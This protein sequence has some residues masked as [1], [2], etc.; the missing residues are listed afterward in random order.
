MGP[1]LDVGPLVQESEKE[2]LDQRLDVQPVGTFNS[3]MLKIDLERSLDSCAYACVRSG[4]AKSLDSH[5]SVR[6]FSTCSMES[7]V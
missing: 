7:L 6:P 4:F 5:A 3:I 2:G 1:K